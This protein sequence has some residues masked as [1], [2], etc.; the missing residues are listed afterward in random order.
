MEPGWRALTGADLD[1]RIDLA[2][3]RRG[4]VL[5]SALNATA[6]NLRWSEGRH[7]GA[8]RQQTLQARFSALDAAMRVVIIDDVQ[9]GG[10]RW[11]G[12]WNY[13]FQQGVLTCGGNAALD[14]EAG[15]ALTEA[16]RHLLMV[17]GGLPRGE[18]AAGAAVQM[19]GAPYIVIQA[20]PQGVRLV[21]A[22]DPNSGERRLATYP[23]ARGASDEV[24]IQLEAG[25]IAAVKRIVSAWSP[26]DE[27]PRFQA[28]R[29]D[30]RFNEGRP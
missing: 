17:C 1:E 18:Q 13:A 25:C 11:A 29:L 2:A 4:S 8:L 15:I 19:G 24:R 20:G 23:H 30:V 5:L 16:V 3:S 12:P 14:A 10:E 9:R 21:S 6:G 27:E 22:T 26:D 28:A 7:D